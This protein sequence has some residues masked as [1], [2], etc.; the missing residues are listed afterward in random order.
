[1]K[2]TIFP[3]LLIG[4]IC[5]CMNRH[6]N[7]SQSDSTAQE[8]LE[9][10]DTIVQTSDFDSLITLFPEWTEDSIGKRLF[11]SR[12]KQFPYNR[13]IP[14]RMADAFFSPD[15]EKQSMTSQYDYSGGYRI[16]TTGFHI[17]FVKKDLEE[18]HTNNNEVYPYCSY[19]V[20]TFSAKGEF[21]DRMEVA[22]HGDFWSGTLRGTR[23]P[24]RLHLEKSIK[25]DFEGE[26]TPFPV[27]IDE[28]VVRFTTNGKIIADTL[29]SYISYAK[30]EED[31]DGLLVHQWD[32]NEE[33]SVHE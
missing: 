20:M 31:A 16:D 28:I 11:D 25:T 9:Q 22:R 27:H 5:S 33:E 13:T 15:E 4:I 30:C 29:R 17:L 18:H 2:K 7:P 10:T 32:R 6:T 23:E 8:I 21:I 1:M 26:F 12:I 24:L 3:L 19:E 14:K